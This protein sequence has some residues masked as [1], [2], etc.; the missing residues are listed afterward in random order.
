M[1]AHHRGELSLGENRRRL[2]FS[3]Y[4][5][6]ILLVPKKEEK[7]RC[8]AFDITNG[9]KPDALHRKNLNP[10]FKWLY[11]MKSK[12]NPASSDSLLIRVAIGQVRDGHPEDIHA[13]LGAVQL[14]AQD[15]RPPEDCVSW[16]RSALHALRRD[17]H[18]VK[19]DD[20][21]MVMSRA[22]SYADSRMADPANAPSNIDYLGNEN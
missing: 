3:A 9:V 4:H 5:W 10:D 12:V 17:G 18:A 6:A 19:I 2:G 20:V 15:V 16:I 13:M 8:Y 22:L 14:P 11:R 1:S 7:H 21:D